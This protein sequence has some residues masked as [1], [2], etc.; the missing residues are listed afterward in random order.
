MERMDDEIWDGPKR[1]M[2]KLNRLRKVLKAQNRQK[3]Y[4][5]NY[6]SNL[7][8]I[9]W[10]LSLPWEFYFLKESLDSTWRIIDDPV[11]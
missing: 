7:K 6:R 4:T 3:C 8:L 2:R 1:W 5:Y 9:V 10:E 11:L